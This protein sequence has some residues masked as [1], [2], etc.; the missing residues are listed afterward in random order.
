MFFI[1]KADELKLKKEKFFLHITAMVE[2]SCWYNWYLKLLQ[3]I[4]LLKTFLERD[5]LFNI[6]NFFF[7]KYTNYLIFVPFFHRYLQ[8]L[9]QKYIPNFEMVISYS[10]MF[11]KQV[12]LEILPSYLVIIWTVGWFF[13]AGVFL[14]VPN[15]HTNHRIHVQTCQLPCLYDR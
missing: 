2:Y 10:K 3:Q 9:D 4:T 6:I 12:D 7:S 1:R 8:L 13:H 14:L 11:S 5:K 15:L